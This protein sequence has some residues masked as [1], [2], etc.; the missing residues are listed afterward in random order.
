MII[1]SSRRMVDTTFREL[2]FQPIPPLL[3]LVLFLAS[4]VGGV[5]CLQEWQT[6]KESSRSVD[7]GRVL[8][9]VDLLRESHPKLR[10]SRV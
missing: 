2:W 4:P 3:L 10:V 7:I 9:S 6:A 1:T 5:D 8:T